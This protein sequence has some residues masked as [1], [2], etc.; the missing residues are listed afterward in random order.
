[1][2]AK[3]VVKDKRERIVKDWFGKLREV[4]E[5]RLH[6]TGDALERALVAERGK[7]K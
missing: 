1:M 6:L 3:Q 7:A 5:I 4:S 2:I